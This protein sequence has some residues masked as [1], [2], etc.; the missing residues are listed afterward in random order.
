MKKDNTLLGFIIGLIAPIL[1]M[2]GFWKFQFGHTSLIGFYEVMM[3]S[4]NLPGLISIGLLGNLG[5]FFV[6][7]RQKLDVSARGVIGATFLYGLVIVILKF[8]VL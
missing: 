1:V 6:F 2:L 4:N 5:A 7:Y 3:Q 8:I